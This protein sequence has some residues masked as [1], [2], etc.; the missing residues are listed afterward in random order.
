M[1]NC[2]RRRAVGFPEVIARLN[3]GLGGNSAFHETWSSPIQRFCH[4]SAGNNH[5]RAP[6]N[7]LGLVDAVTQERHVRNAAP[8]I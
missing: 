4:D 2:D 7:S 5:R 3:P 1:R 6:E 8:R